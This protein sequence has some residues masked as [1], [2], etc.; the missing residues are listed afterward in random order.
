MKLRLGKKDFSVEDL[1]N[2]RKAQFLDFCKTRFGM[3]FSFGGIFLL[4]G[5]PLLAAILVK[6][7]LFLLPAYK[8]LSEAEYVSF[9]KTTCL[10]FTLLYCLCFLFLFLGAAGLG[11]VF[12]QWAWGKGVYFF[13]D[14]LLGIK[15]NFPSYLLLWLLWSLFYFL[16]KFISLSVSSIWLSYLSGG[17]CLLLLPALFMAMSQVLYYSSSL[18]KLFVNSFSYCFKKPLVTFAFLLI[19]YGVLCFGLIDQVMVMVLVVALSLLL[20]LPFYFVGWNLFALTIFDEFTNREYYPAIYQ[21]GLRGEFKKEE[22]R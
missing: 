16:S 17:I 18:T 1:P 3:F 9:Y 5:L 7:Y 19:P 8:S 2:S 20:L 21:K 14:F 12:R 10:I 11:R 13:H 15:K 6:Y 22:E 4:C